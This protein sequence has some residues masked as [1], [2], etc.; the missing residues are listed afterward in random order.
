M[1]H[2]FFDKLGQEGRASITEIVVDE[3]GGVKKLKHLHHGL[4]NAPVHVDS[5]HY[6]KKIK[7]S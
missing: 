7:R 3:D 6:A 4:A 5:V 2:D 1:E